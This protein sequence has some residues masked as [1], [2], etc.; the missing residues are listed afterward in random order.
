M[1]TDYKRSNLVP[2]ETLVARLNELATA[3]TEG[4][5][6]VRRNFTMR[7]PAE[8]DR[9]ADLVI[10]EAARRIAALEAEKVLLKGQLLLTSH[11][12]NNIAARLVVTSKHFEPLYS[13]CENQKTITAKKL[14]SIV[15]DVAAKTHAEAVRL[16]C[17]NDR[18]KELFHEH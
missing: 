8:V 11:D 3:V 18:I 16:I 1:T 4:P 12:I 5:D 13:T 17:I 14:E 9:D 10:S 7:V 15:D 2:T 6:S